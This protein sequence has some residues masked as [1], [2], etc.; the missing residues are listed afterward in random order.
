MNIQTNRNDRLHYSSGGVPVLLYFVISVATFLVIVLSL[1]IAVPNVMLDYLF[2]VSVA[3]LAFSI[4]MVIEDL[5]HPYRP[6]S[7]HL[8]KDK[9]KKLYEFI[10]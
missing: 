9:Y 6:G 1:F 4:L 8:K 7:W 3:L 2:T 10:K 5:N